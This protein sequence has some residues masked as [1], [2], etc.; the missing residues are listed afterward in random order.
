MKYQNAFELYRGQDYEKAVAAYKEILARAPETEDAVSARG[1]LAD[2]LV[3]LRQNAKKGSPEKADYA[4]QATEAEDFVATQ[5]KGKAEALVRVAGNE[6][7]RLAAKEK[8]FGELGRAQQ[9]YDAYFANYSEHY[10]AAQMAYVLA[11]QRRVRPPVPRH[12]QRQDGQ[13][14]R[15]GEVAAPVRERDEKGWRAHHGA[16]EPRPH[17]AEA[18]VRRV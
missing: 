18:R 7:L 13:H 9:L 14:R 3:N 12:L 17:A 8:D 2:C 6:T 1:V 16:A 4:K 5:Y 10:N 15:A 11:T